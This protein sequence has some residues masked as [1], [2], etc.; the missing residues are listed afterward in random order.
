MGPGHVLAGAG[1]FRGD[2][3]FKWVNNSAPQEEVLAEIM[4]EL[5]KP[6]HEGGRTPARARACA[7]GARRDWGPGAAA[8]GWGR[9]ARA[10]RWG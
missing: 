2:G 9:R 7:D 6:R 1:A 5:G 10:R 4:A 3:A 8:R